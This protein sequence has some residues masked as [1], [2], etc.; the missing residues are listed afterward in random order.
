MPVMLAGDDLDVWMDGSEDEA[1]K[2]ARPF[3]PARMANVLTGPREDDGALIGLID[4]NP[5]GS[6]L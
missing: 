5:Q 2:L 1:L 3:D 4:P 6:L